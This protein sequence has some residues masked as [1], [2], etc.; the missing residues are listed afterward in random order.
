MH[1]FLKLAFE[2]TGYYWVPFYFC[3]MLSSYKNLSYGK[4]SATRPVM[5]IVMLI[6]IEHVLFVRLVLRV[7]FKSSHLSPKRRVLNSEVSPFCF[8]YI[9]SP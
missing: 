7:V 5:A 1:I 4:Y 9:S 3:L 8:W 2:G 6:F